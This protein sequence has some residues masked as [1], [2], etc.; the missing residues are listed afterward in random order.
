MKNPSDSSQQ[1]PRDAELQDP[2][3][4]ENDT[5]RDQPARFPTTPLWPKSPAQ[6]PLDTV[7]LKPMQF[8]VGEI[9]ITEMLEGHATTIASGT[10]WGPL[11]EEKQAWLRQ[12][13]T[14]H[15]WK[16]L[17]MDCSLHGVTL[18]SG[19]SSRY[20]RTN[21]KDNFIL[22]AV[23]D[24]AGIASWD[25][26]Q[27][28][29]NALSLQTVPIVFRG[30]INDLHELQDFIALAH[31][32]SSAIHGARAGLIIRKTHNM[33]PGTWHHNSCRSMGR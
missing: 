33:A 2:R 5:G 23:C 11:H 16:T 29:A 6:R 8:V 10:A 18:A 9:V 12:I 24:E 26:T 14:A 15:G 21:G 13:Q 1:T 31:R 27:E 22:Q 7:H 30:R 25:A 32:H 3:Q 4:N 20:H 28:L 17:A 19:P